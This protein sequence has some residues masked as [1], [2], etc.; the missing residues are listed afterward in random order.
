MPS[1]RDV[2]LSDGIMDAAALIRYKVWFFADWTGLFTS[3][4]NAPHRI[5]R[6]QPENQ[7][8]QHLPFPLI[9]PQPYRPAHSTVPRSN[10]SGWVLFV[11]IP[12]QSSLR[13]STINT[14]NNPNSSSEPIN[15][16]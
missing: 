14:P 12:Y 11:P 10:S 4:S 1:D 15:N 2:A 13:V 6:K 3:K 9:L 16:A 8:R 7:R 5:N